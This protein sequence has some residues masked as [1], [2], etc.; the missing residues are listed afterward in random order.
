M[1]FKTYVNPLNTNIIPVMKAFNIFLKELCIDP[2]IIEPGSSLKINT[3][4][5][6]DLIKIDECH[7]FSKKKFTLNKGFQHKLEE[8]Y[9]KYGIYVSKPCYIDDMCFFKLKLLRGKLNKQYEIYKE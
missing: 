2:S 9:N 1:N 5:E 4:G 8:Y 7:I 6:S 3:A